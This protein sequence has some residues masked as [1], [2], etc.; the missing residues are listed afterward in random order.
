V[1]KIG[2]DFISYSSKERRPWMICL[3]ENVHTR[4][5]VLV[6]NLQMSHHNTN[7]P[8]EYEKI[9]SEVLKFNP[10]SYDR[11]VM[12]GDFN[13]EKPLDEIKKRL[14]RRLYESDLLKTCCINKNNSKSIYNYGFDH[15][16]TDGFIVK[17]GDLDTYRMY[18]FDTSDHKPVFAQISYYVTK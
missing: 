7:R 15:I 18:G 6:V 2:G 11:L 1:S 12:C 4:K 9:V 8:Q 10:D 16:I 14:S 17:S 3:F 13:Y 5:R